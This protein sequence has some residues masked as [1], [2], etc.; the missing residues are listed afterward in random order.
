MIKQIKQGESMR[1]ERLNKLCYEC[2]TLNTKCFSCIMQEERTTKDFI[3][4]F[5]WNV[6]KRY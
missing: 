1:E 3:N 5:N 2:V 4:V 6:N